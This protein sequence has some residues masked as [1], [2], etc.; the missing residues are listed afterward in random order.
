VAAL[1]GAVVLTA[2]PA[3][4]TPPGPNGRISFMRLDDGGHWQVWTANPDLTASHQVTAGDGDNGWAT[5]SPDGAH[6]AFDSN[7]LSTEERYLS[8]VFVMRA[9]GS[10]VT[11]VTTIGSLSGVPAWSPDG[12]LLAFTSDGAD[13]PRA[14]GIYVIRPDGNGLRRV[15]GLPDVP[16]ATWLDAPRFS[17]DG[18]QIAFTYYRGGKDL[19]TGYRGEVSSLWVVGSDGTGAHQVTPWGVRVGDADWS[20]DG[21]QLVF[22]TITE[23][24]GNGASVMVVDADGRH[25]RSITRD[26]GIIGIGNDN[27]F[28]FEASFDPVWSPDGRTIMFSHDDFTGRTGGDTGLQTISPDGSGQAYVSGTHAS[29][30][31]VDWGTAPLE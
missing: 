13:Y 6:L 5:W 15:V 2:A 25:L 26:A 22:E 19:H 27:A 20:P 4:A 21:R 11:R 14:Q 18:R 16:G 1:V 8:E 12:A 29:E 9:D 23:H 30:H 28:R 24:L 3:D 10:D 17:P 31:Q 7:R